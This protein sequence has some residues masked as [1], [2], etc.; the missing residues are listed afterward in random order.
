MPGF[1]VADV[2]TCQIRRVNFVGRPEPA[3]MQ[4]TEAFR[5]GGGVKTSRIQDSIMYVR[6]LHE[7]T[8]KKRNTASSHIPSGAGR[9]RFI[10]KGSS[11]VHGFPPRFR[12]VSLAGPPPGPHLVRQFSLYV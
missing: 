2:V 5:A 3:G 6:G 1:N 8:K 7:K 11:Q 9:D 10:R 4:Q 12:A